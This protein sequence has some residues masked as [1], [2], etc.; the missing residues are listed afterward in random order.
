[1]LYNKE[2]V[3]EFGKGDFPDGLAMDEEGGIW[4][5]SIISNRLIRLDTDGHRDVVLEDSDPE[6]LAWVEQ[7]YL[8]DRMDRPQM[9]TMKSSRLQSI[10]S[11][12]FGGKHCSTAH[13]GCLL[14]EQLFCF[15]SPIRGLEPTHWHW[16]KKT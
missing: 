10:S 6:H 8:E 7:A 1:M 4:V 2:T 3:A 12:A 16:G 5:A 14:G 13:L 15:D 9:D 11:I